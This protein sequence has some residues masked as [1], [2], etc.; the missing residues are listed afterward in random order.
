MI[1]V[2]GLLPKC[3]F[4]KEYIS[5]IKRW[6]GAGRLPGGMC[7]GVALEGLAWQLAEQGEFRQR[8][9]LS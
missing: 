8:K 2:I 9:Q 6:G 5:S 7:L 1:F 3:L 4:P